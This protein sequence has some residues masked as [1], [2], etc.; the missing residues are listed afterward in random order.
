MDSYSRSPGC[1]TTPSYMAYRGRK[2]Y[3]KSLQTFPPTQDHAQ[4]DQGAK[5]DD[6]VFDLETVYD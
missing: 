1:T 5:R 2:F 4:T 3:Q 6:E